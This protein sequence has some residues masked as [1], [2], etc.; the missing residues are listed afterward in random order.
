M[1]ALGDV[2][3]AAASAIHD[4]VQAP[5]AMCAQAVLAAAAL[6]VQGHADVVLP[7]G[8][9]RPVS[10][11]FVTIGESGE[12]KSAVD[13]IALWPVRQHEARLRSSYE[14]DLATF[15]N[16]NEAWEKQ[17]AQ[18]LA[19]KS[20]YPDKASKAAALTDVG[21]AP[22]APLVPIITC[23]EPTFEG[24][25]RLL[26][27]GQPSVGVFT[28]EGGQFVGSHAMSEDNKL[29]TCAALSSLWDG[30]PIRRVRQG[31]GASI[32]PGRRVSAHLMLQPGVAAGVLSDPVLR[33][34]GTLS[35]LLVTFPISTAGTRMWREA[36]PESEAA[37]RRYGH[38]LRDILESPFPLAEGQIN[39]L[40]PRALSLSGEARSLWIGFANHIE[41]QIGLGGAL[42]PIRGLANKLP[43]HAA[44]LAAVLAI[45]DDLECSEVSGA[46][47]ASGISLA[48]H[49]AAEAL[50][51]YEAGLADPV[52]VLAQRLLDWLHA[53]WAD[54]SVSLPD[55]YQQGPNAI[56]DGKLALR[57]VRI[58]VEHGWL[59]RIEGGALIRGSKRRDA[60]RIVKEP[61]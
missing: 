42:E 49:Y 56:R 26:A 54:S 4:K 38:R 28:A 59:L 25:V 23:P 35:R 44:R 46:C 53:D 12:R 10:G 43:E 34:Q 60:W 51:L 48:Q 5:Q 11:F 7:T 36:K 29:K 14:D 55:I 18:I 37:I 22:K 58:L 52:L 2:L 20:A 17:R 57:L 33:D 15:N 50:R 6:A 16:E 3:G 9:T 21:P 24:L 30:E 40:A 32:L 45:I 13:E 47:M 19:D 39:E 31:D 27:N 41:Q 61:Q 8:S 1:D